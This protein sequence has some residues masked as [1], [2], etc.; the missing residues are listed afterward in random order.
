[1]LSVRAVLPL[2]CV[3]VLTVDHVRY[4]ERYLIQR[5]CGFIPSFHKPD[6]AAFIGK[7]LWSKH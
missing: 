3:A 4:L 5:Q 7:F 1:M 2:D 6:R